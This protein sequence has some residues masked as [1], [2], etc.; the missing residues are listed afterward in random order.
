MRPTILYEDLSLVNL[1]FKEEIKEAID[2]VIDR[3]WFILGEEVIKFEDSF[4]AYTGSDNCV[5][6]ANGL[7]A[8]VLA[9]KALSLPEDAEVIV[10]SNT[11]IAT[12]L[13]VIQ[14]GLRP[15]LVEPDLNTLTIDPIKIE[16]A[17]TKNTKAVLVVH[18]YGN[19]CDM[20]K[21]SEIANNNGLYLLEDCAQSHGALIA[22]KHT[23]IFGIAGCYSFYPTKNLGALGDA[24]AVITNDKNLADKIRVLRNYGS[25]KKYYNEKIGYNSRLDEIQAAILNVKL[26]YLNNIVAHK[27]KIAE[28]Y[29]KH[30]P[31][32][33]QKIQ[34]YPGAENSYHIYPVLTPNR[35]NL[36]AYLKENNIE[37]EIHYPVPPHQQVGYP[38]LADTPYPISENIHSNIL[39]LPCSTALSEEEAMK[40]TNI[41]H[42]FQK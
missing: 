17:I 5:G 34:T 15:V 40:V 20:Q 36:R 18:L 33:I 35:D 29:N 9:L 2:K 39:S 30:L 24:G 25:Q 26:K 12:V 21:I 27:R 23:G 31:A 16:A 3:G 32:G 14:A 28:I 19:P 41:I 13:A 11:Y 1:P 42:Q 4:A 10:P 37:T 7:D 38:M 6:V 22:G 8:M